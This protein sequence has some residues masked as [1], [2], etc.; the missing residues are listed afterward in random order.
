MC[1]MTRDDDNTRTGASGP[2]RFLQML[3]IASVLGLGGFRLAGAD[4]PPGRYGLDAETVTDQQTGLM[5]QRGTTAT[6]Y[7]W[8]DASTRC[9][10]LSLAG[11]DDWRLPEIKEL[12]SLVDDTRAAPA[13]D[14]LAFPNAPAAV[15]WSAT[16]SNQPFYV[17]FED[18]Q[19]WNDRDA[20]T[21]QYVRCVR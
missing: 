8:A 1:P 21:V 9:D 14:P 10:G 12:L 19:S 15:F 13:I 17:W 16:A 5:W 4:A 18:G 6:T 20:A 7:T 2:L 11:Y 3:F